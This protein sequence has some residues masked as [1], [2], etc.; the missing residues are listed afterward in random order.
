MLWYKAWHESQT[1]FLLSAITI[2]GFCVLFVWYHNETHASLAPEFSTYRG[3]IWRVIYKGYIRQLFVLLTLLLGVGGLLRERAHRTAGFTLS[4]PISRRRLV[5][6]RGVVGLLEVAI[7]SLLPALLVPTLSL[8]TRE[9]YPFS[10]AL[11]FSL[12]W[13]VCGSAFFSIAF[14]SSVVL[15]GEF[16]APVVSIVFVLLYS[17]LVN[18]PIVEQYVPDLHDLMSGVDM[19]YFRADISIL[20]GLPWLTMT[21]ISLL[22]FCL[23]M[24][25]SQ[26]TQHQDF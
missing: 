14:V 17:L 20:T 16:T 12:L 4:L 23:I 7:I 1:R 24:L 26:I 19:P 10:Q 15:G 8:L 5:I 9:T 2:S 13:M 6:T 21:V 22:V 3:Y 11:Q 18:L 25:A